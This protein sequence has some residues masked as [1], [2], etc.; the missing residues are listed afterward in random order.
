MRH[1]EE[2]EG[3]QTKVCLLGDGDGRIAGW[4]WGHTFSL[5]YPTMS[6]THLVDDSTDEDDSCR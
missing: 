5:L 1:K 6:P 3:R 4:G 2:S